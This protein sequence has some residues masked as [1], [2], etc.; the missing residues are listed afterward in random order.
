MYANFGST[1]SIIYILNVIEWVDENDEEIIDEEIVA[2]MKERG[3]KMLRSV[4][5]PALISDRYER[6]VKLGDPPKK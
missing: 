2:A 5:L 3:K 1:R 6:I 4:L